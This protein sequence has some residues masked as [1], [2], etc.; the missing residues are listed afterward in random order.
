M[1]PRLSRLTPLPWGFAGAVAARRR[2]GGS[3]DFEIW[4]EPNNVVFWQPA[5]NPAAYTAALLAAY[6]AIKA[7][8]PEGTVITGGLAP[9]DR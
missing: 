8:D 1:I 4:N 6:A 5:P 9:E 7:V 2:T 3:P